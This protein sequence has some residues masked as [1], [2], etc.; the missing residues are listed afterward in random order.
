[1]NSNDKFEPVIVTKNLIKG[2]IYILFLIVLGG[3]FLFFD[4]SLKLKH[5]EKCPCEDS[6]YTLY[7]YRNNGELLDDNTYDFNSYQTFK[8]KNKLGFTIDKLVH[9]DLMKMTDTISIDSK[10]RG[11]KPFGMQFY[12]DCKNKEVWVSKKHKLSFK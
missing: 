5:T 11:V 10:Q 1:M 6:D 4:R 12:W 8:L 2:V 3:Y 9:I 7:Q